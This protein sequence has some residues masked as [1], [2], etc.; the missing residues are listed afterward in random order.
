MN[1]GPKPAQRTTEFPKVVRLRDGRFRV[2]GA[3]HGHDEISQE[4]LDLL[5]E[6]DALVRW[7]DGAYW[8]DIA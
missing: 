6:A 7:P 1:D 3:A 5:I 4:H 2:L 8:K